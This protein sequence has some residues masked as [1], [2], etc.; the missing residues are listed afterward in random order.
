MATAKGVGTRESD[1]LLVVETHAVEDVAEVVGALGGIGE[2]AV[3]SA[4]G[5]VT[6]RTAGTVGDIRTLHLLDGTD[7]GEDPEIG[8]GDPGELG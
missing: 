8:V 7:T 5:E 4:S 3:G 6:V 1:N 2:T